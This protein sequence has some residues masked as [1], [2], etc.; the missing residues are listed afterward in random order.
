MSTGRTPPGRCGDHLSRAIPKAVSSLQRAFLGLGVML[1]GGLACAEVPARPNF[2]LFI[3]DDVSWN[4]FGCS[5]NPEAR[6]PRI[7]MLAEQGIRFTNFYLTASSCSPSRA[8]IITGRYPHNNGEAVEL[9]RPLPAHLVKFPAILQR[10]GYHTALAGKDHMPQQGDNE[11]AV[12][13]VKRDGGRA[14]G[15]SGGEAHWMDVVRTR[16]R[17]KPFFFWFASHDAHRGWDGDQEWIEDRYGPRHDPATVTVPAALV[18]TPATR[19]DL[20]SHSN[21]VTRFDW[22]VGQVV[23][24][25]RSQGVLDTTVI[26][27]MADNG[28]PFPRGKTRLHDEG[29]KTAFVVHWPA[30]I[31]QP[32]AVTA[33]LLSSIDICPT[34]L[35]LAG[36]DIPPQ[37]QGVS[38]AR[39]LE[40]PS[41]Q[42]RSYSFAEHNWHDYEA[43]GRAVRDQNGFL[44]IRNARPQ[45]AWIGPADSV[46]SPSHQELVTAQRS[47][48]LTS[49]QA[50][51]LREPRPTEEFYDTST[52]PDQI[53]CLIGTGRHVGKLAELRDVLDR[54]QEVTGDSV[55]TNL[56]PDF[57]D[58]D[59]GYIDAA[60]GQ[61]IQ[62]SRVLGV[63]PGLDRGADRIDEPGP[64]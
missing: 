2:V 52:D 19:A 38:F 47:G 8:S 37:V 10:S 13:A 51:V 64:R 60:T 62:G 43:H 49:P 11:E 5:G 36:V 34:V 32:G 58:R 29:M 28:R 27:V 56:S 16:P 1:L 44:F 25:L 57:Y 59:L 41:L 24:E 22:F 17:E 14:P 63:P 18:D 15:N 54:W 46:G 40:E 20:A 12:W 30:G 35:T 6:T 7:D 23:D 48:S 21:E 50:D 39:L 53:S 31:A 3:A 9:H 61:R 33:S 45:K 55:P 42:V 26:M 4:D